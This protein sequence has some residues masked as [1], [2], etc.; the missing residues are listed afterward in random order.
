M[1]E[2]EV[3]V[4]I[5]VESA[6]EAVKR[7]AR[8]I[9]MNQI[10]KIRGIESKIEK[11]ERWINDKKYGIKMIDERINNLL[12]IPELELELELEL[13]VDLKERL[14]KLLILNRLGSNWAELDWC[15][16]GG[17]GRKEGVRNDKVFILTGAC[18]VA[19]SPESKDLPH[20]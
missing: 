19:P 6:K 18:N 20:G 5:V 10:I 12:P 13:D 4:E 1:E 2:V 8:G 11:G 3:E 9:E 15:H 7:R 16:H 17:R 14:V